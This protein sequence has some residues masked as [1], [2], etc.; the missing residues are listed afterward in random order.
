MTDK[1]KEQE[2]MKDDQHRHHTGSE[3]RRKGPRRSGEDRRDMI[4][5][6]P[7]KD[8]R[9]KGEDRREDHKSGWDS[10]TTI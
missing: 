2:L 3:E 5:F 7:D 10:G 6:E 9:R 1:D 8:D 4:R